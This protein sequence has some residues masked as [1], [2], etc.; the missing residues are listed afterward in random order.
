MAVRRFLHLW[1]LLISRMPFILTRPNSWN[2]L[3]SGST[4]RPSSRSPGRT[5]T[6]RRVS[7]A[8]TDHSL[9]YNHLPNHGDTEIS[10]ETCSA[11]FSPFRPH[12]ARSLARLCSQPALQ[13]RCEDFAPSNTGNGYRPRK[14]LFPTSSSVA[15][16]GD[17]ESPRRA[18]QVPARRAPAAGG[19]GEGELASLLDFRAVVI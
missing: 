8:N 19:A 4:K 5:A 6:P 2:S 14:C 16:E 12:H 17:A 18:R 9:G 11:S 15:T 13:T 10:G 3:W 7:L 1:R